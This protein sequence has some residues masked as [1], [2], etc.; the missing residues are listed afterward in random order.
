MIDRH[1]SR[2]DEQRHAEGHALGAL[3]AKLGVT[4]E[5]R[6][7]LRLGDAEV[8][9]DGF[10]E[11]T[12]AEPAIIAEVYAHH[13]ALKGGQLHKIMSDAAKLAAV[14][15]SR[16]PSNVARLLIVLVDDQAAEG[17]RHGWR[18]AALKVLGIEVIVV[19]LPRDVATNVRAAQE[20][21][22]MTN[23]PKGGE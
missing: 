19:P 22:R 12:E 23:V 1:Q 14:A 11:A 17:V 21:Q 16:Y 5:R 8:I 20:R 13:G 4:L 7:T 15:K 2:S 10:C 3:S 18:A 9:V 6:A